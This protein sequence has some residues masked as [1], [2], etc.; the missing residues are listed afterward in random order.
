[1]GAAAGGGGLVRA[2]GPARCRRFPRQVDENWLNEYRGWVYGL[3]FGFQLGAGV[4]TYITTAAVYVA[5]AAALL[6]GSPLAAV[7]VGAVFGLARGLTLLPARTILTTDALVAFHRRL[8]RAQVPCGSRPRPPSPSS[9]SSPAPPFSRSCHESHRARNHL[10]LPAGWEAEIDGGAGAAEPGMESV[11]TPRVH[12]ANF[13]LPP[14][15]GDFG[16][17]AVERMIDGDV[18]VCLLEESH[19]AG[20]IP[21]AR[22]TRAFP[23]SLP[24]TS[25]P[26]A[27]QRPLKGQSGAQVFFTA[28]GR[29][30]VLYVVLGSHASRELARRRHQRGARRHHLRR[31]LAA[32]CCC[33][34]C[35]WP[36]CG[37]RRRIST[38]ESSVA[39]D[40]A[41]V[42]PADRRDVVVVA[43]PA[44]DDVAFGDRGC[45]GGVEG[46]ASRHPGWPP[47]T[48]RGSARWRRRTPRPA[49]DASSV[50]KKYPDTYR[51]GTP[52]VRHSA[53]ARW[54]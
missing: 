12:I 16:S 26:D 31:R 46:R 29:A 14:V 39:F 25:R 41:R 28:D 49:P 13:P 8:D 9:R 6:V 22:N 35:C 20:G 3:G 19:G 44:D 52:S 53:T 15:R 45:V 5:F 51:A 38:P 42:D 2:H 37:G 24:A 4:L 11:L 21:S 33:W 54:A 27:M 40:G 50:V 32:H 36:C 34:A 43:P 10:D 7:A 48:R 47:R 1:M 30:F 17:G 18:L 23:A